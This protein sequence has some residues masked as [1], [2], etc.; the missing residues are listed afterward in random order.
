VS[1]A[2]TTWAAGSANAR[3]RSRVAG[4]LATSGLAWSVVVSLGLAAWIL[5]GL[6]GRD[7]Y[8]T[9]LVVRGYAPGHRVLRP[10]GA[11]GQSFGMAG[12]LLMT[13]PF[14]YMARKRVRAL[15]KAGNL[16]TWLELHLFCGIVGPVLVTFHTCFK[17]NGIVSAAYWSMVVVV[18]SGFAGRYLYVRIPRSIRGTELTRA[19]LDARASEVKGQIAASVASAAIVERIDAFERAVTPDDR[20]GLIDLVFG[21]IALRHELRSFGR[22]LQRAGLDDQIR[23][24]LVRLA[25]ERALLLRR[26]AHLQRTKK[27]F[28][29]WHIFHLPLVYLLLVIVAAHVAITVYMGY[30]PFRW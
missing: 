30:T 23:R 17:F 3:V 18:L 29:M 21:E 4:R 2:A 10:S 15:R 28:E 16:K 20:R 11:A 19:E 22:E 26:L 8:A 7:Y 12:A 24:D 25:A 6:G 27:L 13:M 1:G 14:F 9:P 5:Y